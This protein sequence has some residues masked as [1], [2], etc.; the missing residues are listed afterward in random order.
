MISVF[1]WTFP[2]WRPLGSMTLNSSL[3]A[4]GQTPILT[5]LNHISRLCLS[6]IVH[7][8]SDLRWIFINSLYRQLCLLNYGLYHLLSNRWTQ[9]EVPLFVHRGSIR[10]SVA[11]AIAQCRNRVSSSSIFWIGF[12]VSA[13]EKHPRSILNGVS[14]TFMQRPWTCLQVRM[15]NRSGCRFTVVSIVPFSI[16]MKTVK[17]GCLSAIENLTK[18]EWIFKVFALSLLVGCVFCRPQ[19][20]AQPTAQI[21]RYENVQADDNYKFEYVCECVW[22]ISSVTDLWI[23]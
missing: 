10:L 14:V 16:A 12:P 5:I 1:A 8:K 20:L 7:K 9:A 4:K 11:E 21:L 15:I 18:I 23:L 13:E 3:L 6:T 19:D 2:K 17:Y 22:Q